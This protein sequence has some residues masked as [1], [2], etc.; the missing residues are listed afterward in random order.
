MGCVGAGAEL[1]A[2]W[3]GGEQPGANAEPLQPLSPPSPRLLEHPPGGERSFKE[4]LEMS[5]GK[6]SDRGALEALLFQRVG[7]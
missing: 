1:G 7:V 4:D 3:A 2:R 6:T 5:N